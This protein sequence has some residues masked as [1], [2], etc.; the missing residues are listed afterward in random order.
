M[1]RCAL[2]CLIASVMALA[3]KILIAPSCCCDGMNVCAKGDFCTRVHFLTLNPFCAIDRIAAVAIGTFF[4]FR[5][6]CFIFAIWFVIFFC[7]FFG[8]WCVA[9]VS[10]LMCSLISFF[11]ICMS[12]KRC[13]FFFDSFKVLAI[14]DAVLCLAAFAIVFL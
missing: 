12:V 3:C 6:C 2:I 4:S 13:I 8:T 7:K 1:T 14:F 9:E 5:P 11:V 10:A